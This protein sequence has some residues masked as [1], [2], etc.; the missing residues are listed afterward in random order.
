[1]K[2]A[3]KEQDYQ[4]NIGDGMARGL[5]NVTDQ[6]NDISLRATSI[7][8]VSNW[9]DTETKDWLMS[10]PSEEFIYECENLLKD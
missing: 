3:R 7:M 5:Y 2:T 8:R 6:A 4:L 10:L 1:M 9:F